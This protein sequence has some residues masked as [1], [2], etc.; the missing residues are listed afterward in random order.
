MAPLQYSYFP[1]FTIQQL[2]EKLKIPKPTLRFWEKELDGIIVPLRTSGGQRRYTG[3]HIAVLEEIKSLRDS[4]KSLC[5][6]KQVL[7]NGNRNTVSDDEPVDL[8]SEHIAKA[9][10][11]EINRFFQQR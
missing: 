2:S 4:G 9:V 8:L 6:I 1:P 3:E 7:H 10:R 5:E 11:S